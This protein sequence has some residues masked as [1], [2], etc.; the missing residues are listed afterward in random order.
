V[1]GTDVAVRDSVTKA[2][3]F[4]IQTDAAY[5]AQAPLAS[6]WCLEFDSSVHYAAPGLMY[7][8]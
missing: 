4:D 1:A 8:P 5:G 6:Y 3:P 7:Q 2:V